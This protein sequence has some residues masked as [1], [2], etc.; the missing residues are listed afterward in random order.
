MILDH[1]F[2]KQKTDGANVHET[3]VISVYFQ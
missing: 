3:Q 1:I 2:S